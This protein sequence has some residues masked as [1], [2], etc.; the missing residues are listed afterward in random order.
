MKRYLVLLAGIILVAGGA[1]F[2]EKHHA[3]TIKNHIPPP[4]PEYP[5]LLTPPVETQSSFLGYADLWNSPWMKKPDTGPVYADFIFQN[6][7]DPAGFEKIHVK[8]GDKT[9]PVITVQNREAAYSLFNAGG[10]K[11]TI[12]LKPAYATPEAILPNH[13]D[14]SVGGSFSF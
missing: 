3:A 10:F 5:R 9:E 11:L 1:L 6:D 7:L 2:E 8:P 14:P 4:E 12:N 13:I